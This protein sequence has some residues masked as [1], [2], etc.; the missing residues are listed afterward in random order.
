MKMEMVDLLQG[1]IRR[2][3]GP[4]QHAIV[5]YCTLYMHDA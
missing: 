3:P 4:T 5:T 2:P 1:E